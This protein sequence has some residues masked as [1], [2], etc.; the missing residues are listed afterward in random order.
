MGMNHSNNMVSIFFINFL[1]SKFHTHFAELYVRVEGLNHEEVMKSNVKRMKVQGCLRI[2]KITKSLINR[3]IKYQT[4]NNFE[5]LTR[6]QGNVNIPSQGQ[7]TTLK[8]NFPNI[9]RG[10]INN[11]VFFNFSQR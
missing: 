11:F 6:I 10:L 1:I 5:N 7:R 3:K 9:A 8:N 4:I 2:P